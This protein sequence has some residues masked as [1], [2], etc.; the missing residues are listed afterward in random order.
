MK[1]LV[2]SVGNVTQD[3]KNAQVSFCDIANGV[4]VEV[5]SD[6]YTICGVLID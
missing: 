2:T 6:T 1:N 3:V 4:G 5:M